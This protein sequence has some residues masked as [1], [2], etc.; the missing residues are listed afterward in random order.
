MK[1]K[2]GTSNSSK[3]KW[4]ALCGIL[5]LI[6]LMSG[7]FC[8]EVK[9]D[10][11]N[12]DK[13]FRNAYQ[14][15]ESVEKRYPERR[16]PVSTVYILVYERSERQLIRVIA[17]MWIID[18]GMDFADTYDVDTDCDFEFHEIKKLRDIGPGMLVEV[19]GEDSKV[20]IWLE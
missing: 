9:N 1:N 16:G 18:A 19:D 5:P 14:K 3:R 17:P 2:A 4:T 8:V 10:V 20:L 15:I 7:C 13:Y 6:L 11:R 12:P